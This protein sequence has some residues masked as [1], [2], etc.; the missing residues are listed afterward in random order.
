MGAGV[1]DDLGRPDFVALKLL[2]IPQHLRPELGI[3]GFLDEQ[4][5]LLG[6]LQPQQRLVGIEEATGALLGGLWVS[7][8]ASRQIVAGEHANRG[9][10]FAPNVITDALRALAEAMQ[11]RTLF[12]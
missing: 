8:I 4:E 1:R 7:W 5:F 10:V 12:G 11:V 6:V 3:G 2:V 9:I